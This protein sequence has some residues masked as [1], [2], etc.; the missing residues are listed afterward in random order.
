MKKLFYLL[1]L[2]FFIP[3]ANAQDW[4]EVIKAVASDRAASDEFGNSVSIS[5]NYAI[6]G[7]HTEDEDAA[8]GNYMA[9]AGSA[10]IFERDGSGNWNQVQKIVASDRSTGDEF[11]TSVSISD[12]YAIVGAYFDGEDS[13]GANFMSKAGSV[14]IYERNGSGN[15]NQVQKIVAFDRAGGNRFGYSVSISGNF[16]IAGAYYDSKDA[17][18]G[19]TMNYAGSAYIFERD[20]T[21]TWNLAQKIVASDRTGYDQFGN[22]VSISNNYCIVGAYQADEDTSGGNSMNYAGSAYFFERNGNSTW[23]QVQKIVASDRAMND[24]FGCSVSISGNYA[25]TGALEEDEDATGGNTLS[26]SGS[27]YIYERN[28][29]GTWSQVQKIAA[30]DRAANDYFGC[31]VSISENYIIVGALDEDEDVTGGNTIIDAGSAYLF[32]RDGNGNWNQVQKIVASDR[33]IGADFA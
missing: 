18:G 25:V 3:L 17:T 7:A 28:G 26:R 22:A 5:G 14:Y 8:G 21:G 9:G 19:N 29:N 32:N 4:N 27:A 16:A 31:A 23:S 2:I 20:G 33:A 10:Y 6:I 12:N 1:I 24:Y 30:S 13:A 11:G 15:W